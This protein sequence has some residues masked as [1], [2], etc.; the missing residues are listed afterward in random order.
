MYI[1]FNIIITSIVNKIVNVGDIYIWY[2][3]DETNFQ[4]FWVTKL[5]N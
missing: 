2:R 4:N 3:N 1:H 5:L